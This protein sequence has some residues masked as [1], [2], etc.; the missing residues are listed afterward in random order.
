MLSIFIVCMAVCIVYI[1]YRC[2]TKVNDHFR[3]DNAVKKNIK[4]VKNVEKKA[5]GNYM[6]V[7]G[8]DVEMI[9]TQ[10]T[11]VKSKAA[12]QVRVVPDDSKSKAKPPTG[13]S[14]TVA[15][16]VAEKVYIGLK[17]KQYGDWFREMVQ[18]VIQKATEP[19]S[20]HDDQSN[21]PPNA[22]GHTC[23]LTS[24]V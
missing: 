22:N 18:K 2:T 9:V 21:G 15:K 1:I 3:P 16:F 6:F 12:G 20:T 24:P 5:P 23:T 10:D 11:N 14:L 4:K 17:D 19:A 8:E 7:N 13:S